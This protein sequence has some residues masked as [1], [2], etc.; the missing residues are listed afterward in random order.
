[1]MKRSTRYALTT[2]CV[3]L[4]ALPAVA[5]RFDDRDAL[6]EILV[7]DE[8]APLA[9]AEETLATAEED[10]AAA[11][12]LLSEAQELLAAEQAELIAAEEAA[13]AADEAVTSAETILAEAETALQQGIDD[14]VPEQQVADL[15]QAVTDAEEALAMAQADATEAAD[16]VAAAEEDVA[17]AE[18]DVADAQSEVDTV[19]A[20]VM[21]A[22]AAVQAILDEI[23]GT[24]E[25]V[26][27]MS[28]KQV[29]ALYRSLN[30]AIQTGL[31]PLD[32]DVEMLQRIVDE[33]L[34]NREI[35]A[36]T[37]GFEQEARFEMLAMRFEAKAEAT[38]DDQFLDKADRARGKG[39]AQKEKF[40]AR[41][42]G[43]GHSATSEAATAAAK[44][45]L[46]EST[47]DTTGDV[48]GDVVDDAVKNAVAEAAK[49]NGKKVGH[50]K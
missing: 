50:T 25:L 15:E 1:M 22:E 36:L 39:A 21:E 8:Q 3:L 13:A 49:Q 23:E 40:L 26:A 35:Q 12:A 19:N 32:L 42:D 6:T 37:N 4:L 18:M 48:V 33:N 24:E 31:L 16:A 30:N 2:I 29:F 9:D 38:G 44:Q 47:D 14:G 28:D 11:E 45:A 43:P 34:G 41:L 46:E 7:M 10:L 27:A 20:A 5:A 17:A